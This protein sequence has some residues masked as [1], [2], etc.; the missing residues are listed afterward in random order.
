[1]CMTQSLQIDL[2]FQINPSIS[3][4]QNIEY[5]LE[6]RRRII[7]IFSH[8]QILFLRINFV[9]LLI[10]NKSSKIFLSLI[11]FKNSNNKLQFSYLCI[12]YRFV[13]NEYGRGLKSSLISTTA[14]EVVDLCQRQKTLLNY[15]WHWRIILPL[16]RFVNKW[17]RRNSSVLAYCCLILSLNTTSSACQPCSLSYD[18][19]ASEVSKC[20][21]KLY[22]M[23]YCTS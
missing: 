23:D 1:M 5:L 3:F 19:F 18:E 14:I 21:Y 22:I 8:S 20:D 17:F 7:I 9:E 16:P 4:L 11:R 6:Q 2:K 15:F 13:E 12:R 10:I